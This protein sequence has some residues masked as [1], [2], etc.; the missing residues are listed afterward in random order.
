MKEQVVRAVHVLDEVPIR[1][2]VG[3]ATL[4]GRVMLEGEDRV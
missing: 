4:A 1:G 3:W 2:Q